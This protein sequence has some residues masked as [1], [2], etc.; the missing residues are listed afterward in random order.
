MDFF[1][2]ERRLSSNLGVDLVCRVSVRVP[3]SLEGTFCLPATIFC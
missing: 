1:L 3:P 2:A